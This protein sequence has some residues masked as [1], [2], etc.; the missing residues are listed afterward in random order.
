MNCRNFEQIYSSVIN[1]GANEYTRGH[2][3]KRQLKRLQR[4]T[5]SVSGMPTTGLDASCTLTP[6]APYQVSDGLLRSCIPLL[7]QDAHKVIAGVRM[8]CEKSPRFIQKTG[9]SNDRS[10]LQFHARQRWK[11]QVK[12]WILGRHSVLIFN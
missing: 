10:P 8:P 5:F 6:H 4:K 1:W 12:F 9:S 11:L 2:T 7:L 3:K